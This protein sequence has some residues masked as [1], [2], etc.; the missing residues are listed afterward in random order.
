MKLLIMP[1]PGADLISA[2]I[3]PKNIYFAE[4]IVGASL[5]CLIT[6]LAPL[7]LYDI[8]VPSARVQSLLAPLVKSVV[9]CPPR[10]G[11]AGQAASMSDTSND[12]FSNKTH[13]FGLGCKR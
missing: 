1:V 5:A 9:N 8:V 2:E 3:L 13:I 11:S 10:A 7:L 4:L 12:R 6:K